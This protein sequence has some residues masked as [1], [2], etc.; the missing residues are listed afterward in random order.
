MKIAAIQLNA[1]FTDVKSNLTQSENYIKQAALTDAELVLLPE[2]FTSAI[3]FS[4]KMLDVAIQNNQ[5]L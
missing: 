5:I 4:N 2:F 3:G 1:D